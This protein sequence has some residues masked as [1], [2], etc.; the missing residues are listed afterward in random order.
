MSKKPLRE[1][2]FASDIQAGIDELGYELAT[3]VQS[4]CIPLLR[5]G[6]DIAVISPRGSGQTVA[7]GVVAIEK[8]DLEKDVTQCLIVCPD[9]E[10]ALSSMEEIYRIGQ[11]IENLTVGAIHMGADSE[12]RAQLIASG[13]HILVVTPDVL[14]EVVESDDFDLDPIQMIVLVDADHLTDK[15]A[16]LEALVDETGS[17]KQFA[18]FAYKKTGALQELIDQITQDYMEVTIEPVI[19]TSNV[20]GELLYELGR[21]KKSD[22]LPRILDAQRA[23]TGVVAC[24]TTRTA[25]EAADILERNGYIVALVNADADEETM[26]EA[27]RVFGMGEV[28][29]LVTSDA[30]NWILEFQDPP[31]VIFFDTPME[32]EDYANKSRGATQCFTMATTSDMPRVEAIEGARKRAFP[33]AESLEF[34]ESFDHPA[35]ELLRD[36][37]KRL[38]KGASQRRHGVLECL[39]TRGYSLIDIARVLLDKAAEGGSSG[40]GRR[41]GS[42]GGRGGRSGGRRDG[43][44]RG[45]DKQRDRPSDSNMRRISL[46][47]GY[48][49]AIKPNHVVGAILGETGLEAKSVG[50]IE[51][52]DAKCIVEVETEHA[53][54]IIDRMNDTQ[55]NGVA[56]LAEIAQGNGGGGRS[57]SGRGGGGRKGGGRSG[58][59]RSSGRG[60]RGRGRGSQGPRGGNGPSM[61][62]D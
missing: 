6:S 4:E 5:E 54:F 16:K 59:G 50:A 40:S 34:R 15:A 51:I 23:H 3:S 13:R 14:D 49:H 56:I 1:F 26:D 20:S 38:D 19:D 44:E 25:N 36:L 55:I 48:D 57:R 7:Y 58:G 18:I 31:T 39:L 28:D 35:A 37:E 62:D 2:D 30:E 53:D 41:G 61:G 12:R 10:R 46:N 21:G 11:Q 27:R 32:A 43:G 24:N 22:A 60:G 8:V 45:G 52:Y 42:E 17:D 9:R 47:V 29:F 33:R